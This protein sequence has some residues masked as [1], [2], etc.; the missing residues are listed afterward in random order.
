MRLAAARDNSTKRQKQERERKGRGVEERG[1][2]KGG[3][4]GE[5]DMSFEGGVGGGRES[6]QFLDDGVPSHHDG[7]K[8]DDR[9]T[10]EVLE[11]NGCRNTLRS[12]FVP[13][14]EVGGPPTNSIV[15]DR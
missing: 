9:Y 4:E 5:G 13:W 7:K 14:C 8:D 15:L 1:E 6:Q 11:I 2:E 10:R 12:V 3:K